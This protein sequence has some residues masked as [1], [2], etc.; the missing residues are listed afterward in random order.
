[1]PGRQPLFFPLKFRH[2][3]FGIIVI[4]ADTSQ[5][6]WWTIIDS[7]FWV[8]AYGPTNHA[9]WLRVDVSRRTGLAQFQVVP[10]T[11]KRGHVNSPHCRSRKI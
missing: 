3:C 9:E 1:M 2:E 4:R 6:M 11:D 5:G 10:R 7:K 8:S